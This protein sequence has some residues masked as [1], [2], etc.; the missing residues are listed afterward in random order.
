MKSILVIP[1]LLLIA[2]ISGCAS[3]KISQSWVEPQNTK[4]YRN[5]LI[6][7]VAESEQN[8]R[9]YESYFV[10]NLQDIKVEAEASYRLMGN[11]KIERAN[12]EKAIKGTGI[13]GVIVT[14]LVSVDEDTIYRPTVNY[15]PAYGTGYYGGLY[16]YYPHV[17]TYVS[18]PGYYTT[19]ETYIIETNLY[20]VESEELVWSAR[21]RS[22]SPESVDEVIV[23]LTKLLIEDLEDK[24]LLLSSK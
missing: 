6:I 12:V 9:A 19:H 5:L 17:S 11:Q 4:Q 2:L 15:M 22:F 23:D 7:G 16:T 14:H 13:D 21:T 10:E 3:T 8:R 1:S 18:S 20:D 24:N